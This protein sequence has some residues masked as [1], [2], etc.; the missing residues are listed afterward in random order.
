MFPAKL[1]HESSDS[2]FRP[3]LLSE[4]STEPV[5]C[6]IGAS[7]VENS[8]GG[9]SKQESVVPIDTVVSTN[10]C[11]LLRSCT[12]RVAASFDLTYYL[13]DQGSQFGGGLGRQWLRIRMEEFRNRTK[14][15]D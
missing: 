10:W 11:F 12:N 13:K 9:V 8:Q 3:Y 6:R 5:W 15:S 7:V 14:G 2:F 1:L 4:G